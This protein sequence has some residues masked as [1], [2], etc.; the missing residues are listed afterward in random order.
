[1]LKEKD[2]TYFQEVDIHNTQRVLRALE[3]CISS[4]Q[5]FSSFRNKRKKTRDFR[6]I[7]NRLNGR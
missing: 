6:S 1:M 5:P 7:K 4:G 3:V 2:P